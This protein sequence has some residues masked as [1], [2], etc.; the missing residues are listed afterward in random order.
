LTSQGIPFSAA[1]SGREQA[2]YVE[3]PYVALA[4]EQLRRYE[5][6][7]RGFRLR[8]ALPP[9]APFA[10]T[11]VVAA[12]AVLVAGALLQWKS[13]FARDW[14]EAGAAHTGAIRAGALERTLT[15][16]TLHADVPHLFSNLIF[17]ALF[18]YLLFHALGAGVG[19]LALLGT[20]LFGNWI[21]AWVHVGG[22]ISIG[23]STAV[24]G[25]LGLLSGSEARARH[26]LRQPEARRIAPVGAG[27]L[28]LLY[29]GVGEVQSARNV[30]VLAHVFGFLSGIGLGL[31]L[32]SLARVTLERRGVQAACGAAAF[33]VLCAA[34]V[35]AFLR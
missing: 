34:W 32:G 5:E 6:E 22:H 14:V 7:N 3:E 1:S 27:L 19:A 35:R 12:G 15:A 26:L 10:R 25:A 2:L 11:G 4:L 20:G 33:L 30:D 17:G 9:P 29:L 23:A 18:A 13:A 8:R 28:L 24:F 21:N 16:L 31:L